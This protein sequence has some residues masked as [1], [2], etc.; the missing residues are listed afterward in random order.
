MEQILKK[1]IAR[2]LIHWGHKDTTTSGKVF[3]IQH[4]APYGSIIF[5]MGIMN[6]TLSNYSYN[7]QRDGQHIAPYCIN[8]TLG[9]GECHPVWLQ[10]LIY[11]D[12]QDGAC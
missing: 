3:K 9:D 7:I 10:N 4:D 8:I 12:S 2:S 1:N 6:V 5:N 11:R